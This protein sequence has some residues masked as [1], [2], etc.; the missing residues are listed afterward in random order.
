[1]N[2]LDNQEI[3]SIISY[4]GNKQQ[5]KNYFGCIASDEV[6]K[7]DPLKPYFYIVN[8]G[9]RSSGGT[10]WTLLFNC[11]KD[12]VIY[13][14]SFGVDPPDHVN[15]FMLTTKKKRIINNQVF[16]SYS[17][18]RCGWFSIYFALKLGLTNHENKFY[19][20]C[21]Y[22]KTIRNAERVIDN[23]Q[24]SVFNRLFD[25][26]LKNGAFEKN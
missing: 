14:D 11:G 18:S 15:K 21:N 5:R 26:N 7:L 6:K 23:Y 25:A 16:Q 12:C 17:S 9:K 19:K 8:L 3:D 24:R 2:E 20:I 10:H 13:F 1:M 4:I 22:L